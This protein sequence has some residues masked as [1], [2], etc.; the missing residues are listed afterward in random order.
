M[1]NMQRLGVHEWQP[2]WL[3]YWRQSGLW[4]AVA[5]QQWREY[6]LGKSTRIS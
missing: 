1:Y 2:E 5:L 6:V 3:T 4:E